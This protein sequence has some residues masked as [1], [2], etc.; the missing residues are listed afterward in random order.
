VLENASAVDEASLLVGVSQ[1]Y[2]IEKLPQKIDSR[3]QYFNQRVERIPV[4]VTDVA[5]PLQN[6]IDKDDPDFGWQNFLKKYSEPVIKPVIVETGWVID[7]PYFG[8]KKILSQM[9]DQ[10]QALSI[11]DA[12][13]EN[14][15]VA[16]I[17]K[18]PN[19]LSRVLGEVVIADDST[20]LKK[21]LAKLFSPKVTGGAV[22]AVQA[23]KDIK[24]VNIRQL[25]KPQSFSATISGS[26]TI[27]AK[28][29]GHIDQ[30]EVNFQLLLDLIEV[31][32][33]WRL[34]DIT[35]IDIKEIK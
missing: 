35:V 8:K 21:E 9:P 28:H 26:A 3:W 33:Q 15:R 30:R 25:D 16:F 11:V 2:F 10:Q 31:D 22:G 5:G 18:E 14:S 1:K 7:I 12:V 29:W 27:N 19:N 17:E 13:L 34:A 23:F 24:I 32:N 20:L 6:L 4:I